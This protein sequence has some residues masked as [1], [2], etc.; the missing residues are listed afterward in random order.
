MAWTNTRM[1]THHRGQQSQCSPESTQLN[2][3]DVTKCRYHYEKPANE[4]HC[5]YSMHEKNNNTKAQ[6]RYFNANLHDCSLELFRV[7]NPLG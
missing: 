3:V 6:L 2:F 4:R 7:H 1:V 5:Q